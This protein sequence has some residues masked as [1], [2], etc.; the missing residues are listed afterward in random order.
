MAKQKKETRTFLCGLMNSSLP[1]VF[2]LALSSRH[3]VSFIFKKHLFIT[4]LDI[5]IRAHTYI[6]THPT[7]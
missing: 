6:Y 2:C 3:L 5:I 4:C 1:Y 7:I